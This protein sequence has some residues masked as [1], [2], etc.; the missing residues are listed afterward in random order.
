[1]KER[2]IC[3]SLLCPDLVSFPVLS[4]IKPQAPLLQGKSVRTFHFTTFYDAFRGA[5]A[6]ILRRSN[7]RWRTWWC[8]SVNSFKFRSCDYTPFET[9][10]MQRSRGVSVVRKQLTPGT[11]TLRFLSGSSRSHPWRH[12]ERSRRHSL[13]SGLQ[14]YLIIFSNGRR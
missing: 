14:W 5:V 2:S 7:G 13:R 8:H 4:Q 10:S 9:E 12:S 1:M 11:R 3:Q 6:K